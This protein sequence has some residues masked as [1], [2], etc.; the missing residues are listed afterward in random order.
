MAG[1]IALPSYFELVRHSGNG[2]LFRAVELSL[3][4]L[5]EGHP[6]H[7]HAE[8]LRG[9][10]KTTIMRAVK[11][12]LPPIIR[13][14]NC[15]YNCDPAAPHCPEHRHLSPQE[16]SAIGSETIP[17]PFL[18][19][20]QSA[21]IGTVVGTIDLAKLTDKVSPGAL[22]LPG[23]IVQAHRGI[24]FVDEINRLADTSPELADVLLDVMG[25]KP[26]RIQ[27]EE[28]G[29]PAVE[30]P[31]A[32]TVW[33]ASN[34]D[35]DPG[36]LAQVRRQLSDRFDVLVTMG[37]PNNYSAV[38]SILEN[39]MKSTLTPMKTTPDFSIPMGLEKIV[40]SKE[41]R[42]VLATI[43]VDF[44]LESL[45]AVQA[46]EM[47]AALQALHTGKLQVTLD[48]VMQVV[49]LTL[50]H[51]AD[52]ATVTNILKYLANLNH[53]SLSAAS[54]SV[55]ELTQAISNNS[56]K[57]TSTNSEQTSWWRRLWE[58]LRNR[59]AS[60][61][62]PQTSQN[63]TN[64]SGSN[65]QSSGQGSPVPQAI[66]PLQTSINAPRAKA[67]PLSKLPVDKFISSEDESR[68]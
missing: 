49:P 35:E 15:L 32:V 4:A 19:I 14:K 39:R 26:G 27:I 33:A 47:A 1:G 52:H 44:S 22:L 17:C 65:R 37:R 28:T 6:F 61:Q 21:K 10:G 9:T 18:E 58:G 50:G 57:Q 34:P 64:S 40:I 20:S 36:A 30:L 45:R 46:M 2:D 13:I 16:I 23:T 66:D 12:I 11:D 63:Q 56:P 55:S 41:I 3:T 29:M 59:A 48:E 8:G 24:V 51:R 54:A 43:Y 25:T 60:G 42:N 67:T 68:G 62:T 7:L 31:L 38:H 53:P 5:A